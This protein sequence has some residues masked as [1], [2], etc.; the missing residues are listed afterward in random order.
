MK[1]IYFTILF[2]FFT[3]GETEEKL[4]VTHFVCSKAKTGIWLFWASGL[5]IIRVKI[6]FI[7]MGNMLL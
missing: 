5:V 4:W 3:N 7:R 6:P 1:A 2:Y